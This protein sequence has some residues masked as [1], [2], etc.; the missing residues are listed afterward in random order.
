M[1]DKHLPIFRIQDFDAQT[2]RE[3]YFYLNSFANHLR[4]HQFIQKPHKHNF[5]IVLLLTSGS[6]THTI[7]FNTYPVQ[8]RTVYFLRP[9]QVHSWQFTA[10]AA[11]YIIFFTSEFYLWGHPQNKL[12][13]FPFFN[14]LLSRP[15]LQ[16]T[17]AEEAQLLTVIK[18]I[19]GEHAG[20]QSKKE[21]IIRDYLDILLILLSRIYEAQHPREQVSSGEFLQLQNLENL[22]DQ[23]YKAHQPVSFYAE[24]LHMTA[25][26]LN[27]S[28]KRTTGKTITELIQNRVVL[29]AQRLLVHSPLTITQVAAELGYFDNSYFSR[30]FKKHAGQ[31]PEQFRLLH[32]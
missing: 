20:R 4:E 31:T 23:H 32:Q 22:I 30:F 12:Y 8:P 27:E 26:Q 16:V 28:S 10:D 25:K 7:D 3:Q 5:Y 2:R 17:E 1:P 19:E 15:L 6:G 21:D 14:A 24:Q 18:S 11:G 9:G 13:D 29:E